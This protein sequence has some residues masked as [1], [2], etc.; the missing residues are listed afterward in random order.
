MKIGDQIAEIVIRHEDV[1]RAAARRIVLEL[2]RTV[3]M[4]T[5][6]NT[7]EAYPHQLSGGM[8]QRVLIAMAVSCRPSILIADEPTT[9]LDVTIQMQILDLIKKIKEE[10]GTS[11][12]LITH[13]F[14][15]VAEICDRTNV[16]YA[17]KIVESA[18]VVA[19]YE[20]AKHPYTSGLL[21]CVL[22]PKEFKEK[23]PT[24]GGF[25]PD[26][27]N[28]PLGCRF[29]PRCLQAKPLCSQKGP[30]T[31]EIEPGH[32]VSCWLHI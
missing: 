25:V 1:D 21:E 13:D 2:L 20:N 28:P 4:P 30:P 3:R 10:L 23:L 29:H 16:M 6:S 31:I 5:P 22:S 14:G 18:D 8:R 11:L 17:G 32:T 26:L 15:I 19:L 27:A 12:M 7:Y 24:I 9:A